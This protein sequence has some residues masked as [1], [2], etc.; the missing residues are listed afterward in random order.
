MANALFA[1]TLVCLAVTLLSISSN[2][3]LGTD[4]I[5]RTTR[6]RSATHPAPDI[7]FLK[8]VEAH[9]VTW[10]QSAVDA[11]I[12]FS[13]SRMTVAE[14]YQLLDPFCEQI[15][16]AETQLLLQGASA[17]PNFE[18]LD[19]AS[20]D[21]AKNSA[22]QNLEVVY[23]NQSDFWEQS[24]RIPNMQIVKL[25]TS[26]SNFLRMSSGG[27]LFE[28]HSDN[29]AY[30]KLLKGSGRKWP[31]YC[32]ELLDYRLIRERDVA[33]ELKDVRGQ[34][35]TLSSKPGSATI[36][37]SYRD[38]GPMQTLANSTDTDDVTLSY[39]QV[40]KDVY[41]FTEGGFFTGNHRVNIVNCVKFGTK[42]EKR[43]SYN[44]VFTIAIGCF[45][46][47]Y[48]ASIDALQR[49]SLYVPFLV[50]NEDI[51]L[52]IPV[53]R[54]HCKEVLKS[55]GLSEGRIVTGTIF[56]KIGFIPAGSQCCAASF[57]PVRALSVLNRQ[58]FE[59]QQLIHSSN[60][61][62]LIKRLV[63]KKRWLANYG[64]IL[65]ILK[66]EA[67]PYRL[68]V[69]EFKDNPAP[70]LEQTRELFNSAVMVVGPHGAGLANI[71]YSNPGTCV[72]E[73]MCN[74]GRLPGKIQFP[75][76]FLR[77]AQ[78]L[79]QIYHVQL[80]KHGEKEDGLNATADDLRPFVRSCLKF[81]LRSGAGNDLI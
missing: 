66:E 13:K 17:S 12:S 6:E 16:A 60:T 48:H 69:V 46:N 43:K 64:E 32:T 14:L 3:R 39:I 34:P 7:G 33:L 15:T 62:V 55:F 5:R 58:P 11:L 28:A 10:G 19:A 56:A 71:I 72:V 59:G 23:A 41:I 1:I 65:K 35:I 45:S 30:H 52:H 67:E 18:T 57:A 53:Y 4:M 54:K 77:L 79:S 73:V 50:R 9:S 22:N 70:S 25:Q 76:C 63:K 78:M 68:N 42:R 49:I 37:E 26:R 29:C 38:L 21:E 24:K 75:A 61:I 80:P 51:K 47:Y 81:R 2:L 40:V 27:Y 31:R 44:R 36:A 74:K 8:G 20:D